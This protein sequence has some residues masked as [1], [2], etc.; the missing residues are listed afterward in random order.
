LGTIEAHS[1]IPGPV[2]RT[3]GVAF[4]VVGLLAACRT[5]G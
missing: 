4:H 5:G 1:N 2:P 3:A